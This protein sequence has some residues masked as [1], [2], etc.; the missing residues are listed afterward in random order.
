M[1]AHACGAKNTIFFALKWWSPVFAT[2]GTRLWRVRDWRSIDSNYEEEFEFT[3]GYRGYG[4]YSTAYAVLREA[5]G[6]KVALENVDKVVNE[7][8]S[9]AKQDDPLVVR[10]WELCEIVGQKGSAKRG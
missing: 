5:F 1:N 10:G 7:I 6:K 3:W 8:V 9:L 2:N 4:C